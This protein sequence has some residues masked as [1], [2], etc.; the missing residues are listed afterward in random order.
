MK[1]R[2]IV[3]LLPICCVWGADE[4]DRHEHVGAGH[5]GGVRVRRLD[6][7]ARGR[8]RHRDD[9]GA[10]RK[11]EVCT[12][13]ERYDLLE[14]VSW[15]SVRRSR[16]VCFALEPEASRLVRSLGPVRPDSLP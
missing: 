11:Q 14:S 3:G 13:Q 15:W 9:R 16:R 10:L 6:G 8:A 12:P 7:G 5:D 1:N 4:A 2:T